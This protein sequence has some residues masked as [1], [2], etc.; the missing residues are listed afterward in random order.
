MSKFNFG[1][2]FAAK[3]SGLISFNNVY[4]INLVEEYL[5]ILNLD[6]SNEEW[7]NAT[8][9]FAIQKG[10][11]ASPKDYKKDPD[12]YKG[13]VGDICE[14]IRVVV[15][16]RTKSPDLYSILK[17]LGKDRIKKRIELYKNKFINNI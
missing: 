8:K 2:L 14:A 13:H 17:I 16:G 3:T 15:T 7:F 11:A 5:N 1:G 6:V 4:D 10:Y 9:E 12:N